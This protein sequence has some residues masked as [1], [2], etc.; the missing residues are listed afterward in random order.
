MLVLS[1]MLVYV[2]NIDNDIININVIV[3]IILIMRT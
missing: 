1:L 3:F 2:K